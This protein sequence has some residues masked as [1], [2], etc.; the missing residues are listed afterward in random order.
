MRIQNTR[1]CRRKTAPTRKPN[2]HVRAQ[3]RALGMVQYALRIG[4]CVEL[5][6]ASHR[7]LTFT[8]CACR[9]TC[10]GGSL[11]CSK[12]SSPAGSSLTISPSE[13]SLSN[14]CASMQ[15]DARTIQEACTRFRVPN[16]SDRRE[17]SFGRAGSCYGLVD[18][19]GVGTK[20][21]N[22]PSQNA[23]LWLSVCWEHPSLLALREKLS[24]TP[25]VT[26][27]KTKAMAASSSFQP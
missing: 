9:C 19:H 3:C 10:I 27:V 23:E 20:S 18:M 14:T 5:L 8:R 22:K 6:H 26:L 13:Y 1:F 4:Q 17:A 21:S 25:L 7:A 15:N 16:N 24:C 11:Y 12:N 2:T